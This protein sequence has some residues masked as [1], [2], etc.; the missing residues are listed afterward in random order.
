M[1]LRNLNPYTKSKG[2]ITPKVG[3]KDPFVLGL[4]SRIFGGLQDAPSQSCDF[5]VGSLDFRSAADAD[6]ITP[7]VVSKDPLVL[8]PRSRNL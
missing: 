6:F 8:G 7:N 4:Q 1:F 5:F 2:F 3:P